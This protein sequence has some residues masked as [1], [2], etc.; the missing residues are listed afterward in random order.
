VK[1]S[2]A[3]LTGKVVVDPGTDRYFSKG[4]AAVL[5]VRT[6]LPDVGGWWW[7]VVV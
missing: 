7:R 1:P 2:F 6:V 5:I 4:F 3:A